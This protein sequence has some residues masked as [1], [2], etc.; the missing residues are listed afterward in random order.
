M[1][2]FNADLHIHSPYSIAV[3]QNMNLESIYNTAMKKGLNIL[4]TGDI[5]QPTWRKYLKDNLEFLIKLINTTKDTKI[6]KL[7]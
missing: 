3:S 1:Q 2:I 5:T 6:T 4:S 7:F